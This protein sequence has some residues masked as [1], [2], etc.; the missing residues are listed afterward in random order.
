MPRRKIGFIFYTLSAVN[1]CPPSSPG[2]AG[3]GSA[4]SRVAGEWTQAL[5]DHQEVT[6]DLL[7]AVS[8]LHSDS[9]SSLLSTTPTNRWCER[10]KAE[11]DYPPPSPHTPTKE[12]AQPLWHRAPTERR[13]PRAAPRPVTAERRNTLPGGGGGDPSGDTVRPVWG[14]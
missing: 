2:F 9:S 14:Q 6:A 10:R 8:P 7:P 12:G 5:S 11:P 13:P 4:V 3:E 1:W